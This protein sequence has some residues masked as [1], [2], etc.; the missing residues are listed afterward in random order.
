MSAALWQHSRAT[1][2]HNF[3]LLVT[4]CDLRPAS[5]KEFGIGTFESGF[6]LQELWKI[7]GGL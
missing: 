4:F 1:F 6:E 5:E 2:A 3:P 7:E